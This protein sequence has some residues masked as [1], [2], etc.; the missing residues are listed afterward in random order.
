MTE[1]ELDESSMERVAWWHC[2]IPAL[3]IMEAVE[4]QTKQKIQTAADK[5]AKDA[6]DAEIQKYKSQCK[7]KYSS[8]T[9]NRSLIFS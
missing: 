2:I 6:A 7:S 8:M 1:N 5:A 4:L 9:F 3:C